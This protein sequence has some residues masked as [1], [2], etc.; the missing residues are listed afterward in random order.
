VA[1][2][3]QEF[4]SLNN[5]FGAGIDVYAY[6]SDTSV[7]NA[8]G[9]ACTYNSTLKVALCSL[10]GLKDGTANITLR[11]ASTVALSTVSSNAVP[12]RVSLKTAASAK[13]SFDKTSYAPGEKA[14]ALVTV[15]DADGKV[16][17]AGTY[18]NLFA[19]GGIVTTSNLTFANGE[20]LT[21][22]AVTTAANPVAS[23]DKP[24]VSTDPVAQFTYFMPSIGGAVKYTA[25]GGTSLPTAGQVAITATA[26]V[27]D[28]GAA[29]LAAVTALATTVASL[30]TLIVTLTNLVLKIQ[31][32]VRA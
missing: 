1:V 27:T 13:I 21:S 14:T 10:A 31:K 26:N 6:S 9:T 24:V 7:I 15:L 17:P 20:S 5:S 18:S 16:M 25:T 8:N 28:S 19:T 22:V 23:T 12:V 3:G 2:W 30:R 29:A 11:D 4:D 32:K